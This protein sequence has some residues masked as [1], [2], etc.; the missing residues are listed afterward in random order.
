MVPVEHT[1]IFASRKAHRGEPSDAH[2]A[3][4]ASVFQMGR[5][6]PPP[7]DRRRYAASIYRLGQYIKAICLSPWS[8]KDV[9]RAAFENV[10][11]SE[12]YEL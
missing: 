10:D 5:L 7:G 1:S 4:V 2:G 11:G 12:I 9:N 8:L 3:A 6:L